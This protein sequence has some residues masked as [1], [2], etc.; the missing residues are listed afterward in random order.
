MLLTH[1]DLGHSP[2]PLPDDFNGM[3]AHWLWYPWAGCYF[4]FTVHYFIDLVLA[5]DK[6]VHVLSPIS[7]PP[8]RPL[9]LVRQKRVT[10][11]A[12]CPPAPQQQFS[13][14]SALLPHGGSGQGQGAAH[15]FETLPAL[16]L[17]ALRRELERFL[18]LR[19]L[20]KARQPS[21]GVAA[22]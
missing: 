10:S 1:S 8:L 17:E 13:P 7:S 12:A 5:E 21:I 19:H 9:P 22:A 6:L 4:Y 20:R 18:A 3:A 16:P 14:P 11:L 15:L 2:L